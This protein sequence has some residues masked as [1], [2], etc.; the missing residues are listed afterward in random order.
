MSEK[1]IRLTRNKKRDEIM[2]IGYDGLPQLFKV[3]RWNT[4]VKNDKHDPHHIEHIPI[5]MYCRCCNLALG[6]MQN[7]IR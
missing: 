1:R 4:V 7:R 6:R 3:V 2:S 5:Y